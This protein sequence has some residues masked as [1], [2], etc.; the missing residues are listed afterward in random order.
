MHPGFGKVDFEAP[1]SCSAGQSDS[2][3]Q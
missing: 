1:R 3:E 2:V